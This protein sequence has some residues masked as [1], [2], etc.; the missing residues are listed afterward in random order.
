LTGRATRALPVEVTMLAHRSRSRF[1]HPTS[2]GAFDRRSNPVTGIV[3]RRAVTEVMTME[4][5]LKRSLVRLASAALSREIELVCEVL[6]GVG[7]YVLG[8]RRDVMDA[9][10]KVV[11]PAMSAARGGE[12]CVRLARQWAGF[13]PTEKVL[14]SVSIRHAGRVEDFDAVEM[15]LPIAQRE[16][17]IEEAAALARVR[18]LLV[19]PSVHLA[20]VH[21]MAARRFGALVEAVHDV[22]HA[23]DRMR[24]AA[25]NGAPIDVLFLDDGTRQVSKL[26]EQTRADASLGSARGVVA[27]ALTTGPERDAYRSAG[28]ALTLSKPV[29]PFELRDSI[30]AQSPRVVPRGSSRKGNF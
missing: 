22:Q 27:T 29:L 8:E 11:G 26:L 1:D 19:V 2:D 25:A 15:T 30:S 4:G 14:V 20:R 9:V 13:D 23:H 28:A 10:A 24:D 3:L 5:A 21:G 18:V 16:D 12:V 17:D 7:E 6:P